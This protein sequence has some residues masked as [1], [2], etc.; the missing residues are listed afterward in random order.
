MSAA[1]LLTSSEKSAA[2]SALRGGVDRQRAFAE[3]F[4]PG[5]FDAWQGWVWGRHSFKLGIASIDF[6]P[7]RVRVQ[8]VELHAIEYIAKKRDPDGIAR[9]AVYRHE[10][11]KPYPSVCTT[12]DGAP[13]APARS[14]RGA[15]KFRGPSLFALGELYALEGLDTA[16]EIVRWR[17]PKG[18]A[19]VG[20]PSADEMHILRTGAARRECAPRWIFRG[21]SPY[22]LTDRGIEK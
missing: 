22:T 9:R 19:L 2:L 20:C 17:A 7:E 21:A 12:D 13:E 14:S 1:R 15:P 8:L 18:V 6:A 10:H 3:D 11:F 5:V 4:D 16:G